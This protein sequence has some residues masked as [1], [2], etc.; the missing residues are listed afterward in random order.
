MLKKGKPV[1]FALALLIAA[2]TIMIPRGASEYIGEPGAAPMLTFREGAE[3]DALGRPAGIT[4]ENIIFTG[5]DVESA[6]VVLSWEHGFA[7]EFQLRESGRLAFS[8]TTARLTPV[9]GR[10]SIWIDD[11]IITAPIVTSHITDGI[12]V[13]DGLFTYTEA[14]R[15]ADLITGDE[16]FAP[17]TG[18]HNAVFPNRGRVLRFLAGAFAFS[19][20]F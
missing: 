5:D 3:M 18:G 17:E 12:V 19:L 6:K 16:P 13:I 2:L 7:V 10:I 15:L 8:E 1:F 9:M 4:A 14:H 20:F 11:E